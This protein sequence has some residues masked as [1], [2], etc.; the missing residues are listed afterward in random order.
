MTALQSQQQAITNINQLDF[1]KLYT[2]EEYY[3]WQFPERVELIDGRSEY[4]TSGSEYDF[5]R[6]M[7]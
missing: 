1:D 2:Y 7:V 5:I 4:E 6:I 3:T